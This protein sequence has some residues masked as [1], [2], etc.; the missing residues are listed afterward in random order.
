MGDEVNKMEYEIRE[1]LNEVL[2]TQFVACVVIVIS[3]I[4]F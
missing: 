4:I 2:V 1:K 3:I